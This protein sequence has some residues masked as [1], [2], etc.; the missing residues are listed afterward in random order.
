MTIPCLSHQYEGFLSA[1][2]HLSHP[3]NQKV[4]QV[5]LKDLTNHITLQRLSFR[6]VVGPGIHF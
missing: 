1:K 3:C 5:N 6:N 4:F 2:Q